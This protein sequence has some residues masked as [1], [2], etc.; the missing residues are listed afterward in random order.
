MDDSN[1]KQQ[2]PRYLA[3]HPSR[4]RSLETHNP[5]LQ[6]ASLATLVDSQGPKLDEKAQTDQTYDRSAPASKLKETRPKPGLLSR[7]LNLGL[8]TTPDRS[9]EGGEYSLRPEKDPRTRASVTADSFLNGTL[10]PQGDLISRRNI[11]SDRLLCSVVMVR[12]KF[13]LKLAKA[14]MSY[15]APSHRIESQLNAASQLLDARTGQLALN[16]IQPL[17]TILD[18][19]RTP[20]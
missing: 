13:I 20:A 10:D 2:D 3:E 17:L 15:G 1:Q 5:F 16:Y 7:I 18:R 14:L 8:D 12:R 19:I 11:P 9:E 6:S 4:A